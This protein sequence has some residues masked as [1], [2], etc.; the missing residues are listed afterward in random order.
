MTMRI[1]VIDDELGRLPHKRGEFLDRWELSPASRF[2]RV[3]ECTFITSQHHRSHDIENDASLAVTH[4]A[5]NPESWAL[6]LLDM[7]FDD[8][9]LL[10][11]EPTR[12][13][14]NFGLRIQEVLEQAF[15]TL[16]IV[17]FTAQAQ[18]DLERQD[19]LY[20]SKIDG[21]LDDLRLLLVEHG[22]CSIEDK[23][24]LLGIPAD[25]VVGSDVMFDLYAHVYRW[26][27]ADTPLLIRGQTGTGKEHLA[28]YFHDVSPHRSGPLVAVQVSTIASNLYES[29]L[30]GH[31][32][33]AFTGADSSK[34]GLFGQA[35]AGTLFLDEIGALPAELQAKLLRVIGERRFRRVGGT[36]DL[37]V[38]CGI[39]AATQDDLEA[40]AFRK[41]LLARFRTVVVPPLHER[42]QE[43]LKLA[44]HFLSQLQVEHH[45]PKRGMIL[46]EAASKAL[47][48]HHFADNARGL[49]RA[50]ETAVAKRSSNSV[51][52][53]WHLGLASQ[54]GNAPVGS[55]DRTG[56]VASPALSP[57]CELKSLIS[58][59][60]AA[61]IPAGKSALRGALNE[62]DAATSR[63]RRELAYAALQC[64]RHEV[65]DTIQVPRAMQLLTNN[66]TPLSTTN[67]RRKL[68]ELLGRK[69]GDAIDEATLASELTLREIK[70]YNSK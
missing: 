51:V 23:K 19:G 34:V 38:R 11:G 6:V 39:V 56:P 35:E 61:E 60:S 54:A 65:K 43:L 57:V 28:R 49:R 13:N 63:I 58:A 55:S 25:T 53:P 70:N 20:L 66:P 8:G 52:Q 41:D 4:V 62:L 47:T 64:T 30:F 26:A 14:P 24:L 42:P 21:S 36:S 67:A 48:S 18:K 10:Q 5:N 33:G 7:Q 68:N 1:L 69:Q 50:I 59:L 32:K 9:P 31:E 46:S 22:R 2:S 37:K 15:P 40:N 17:Q 12:G 16:P 27:R 44:Q 29:E 45:P 3:V